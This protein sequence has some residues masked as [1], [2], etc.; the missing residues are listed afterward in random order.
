LALP[1]RLFFQGILEELLKIETN[2]GKI[3]EMIREIVNG[4]KNEGLT[5]R[6]VGGIDKSI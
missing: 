1:A 2:S 6:K 4:H 3:Q 5:P